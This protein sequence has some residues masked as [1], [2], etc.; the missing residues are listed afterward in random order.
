[1]RP[2]NLE[3]VKKMGFKEKVAY[4]KDYQEEKARIEQV[5]RNKQ[6]LKR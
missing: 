2:Y 3:L 5:N 1:M 4:T 6:K